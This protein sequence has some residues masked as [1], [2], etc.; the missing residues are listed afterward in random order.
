M[1]IFSMVIV[2]GPISVC[3]VTVSSLYGKLPDAWQVVRGDVADRNNRVL[4]KGF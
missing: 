3:H 1:R 4:D 2:S